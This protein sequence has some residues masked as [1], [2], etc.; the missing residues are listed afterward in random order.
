MR[1]SS[2][3]M[4]AASASSMPAVSTASSM[5]AVSPA[6]S[7]SKSQA[8]ASMPQVQIELP[9]IVLTLDYPR[10]EME[11]T[12]SYEELGLKRSLTLARERAAESWDMAH[13]GIGETARLG[14]R[15]AAIEQGGDLAKEAGA[16]AWPQDG[17]QINVTAAP[18][19]RI[20]VDVSLG[21]LDLKVQ[22]GTVRT[23]SGKFSVWA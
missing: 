14:D 5:P 12:G 2:A 23:T 13:R 9:S 21:R 6:S 1:I 17:Q 22:E 8:M 19:R 18:T 10:V 4:T 11:V 16:I 3:S 7:P 20:P 15:L